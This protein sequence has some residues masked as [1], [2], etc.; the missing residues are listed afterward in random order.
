VSG[1]PDDLREKLTRLNE[2]SCEDMLEAAYLGGTMSD[3]PKEPTPIRL[4]NGFAC[5]ANGEKEPTYGEYFRRADYDALRTRLR[6]AMP[7]ETGPLKLDT[8][9]QV[10]FYEQ[11]HY[12]LS[13]FSAFSLEWEGYTFPTSEHAYQWEKFCGA[14]QALSVRRNIIRQS[15]SAHEAFKYAE[16]HAQFKRAN[17][18]SVKVEIMLNILRAKAE[19]HEYVRRK[20]LQTGDLELIENSWRDDFWGWGSNR[21]GQNMLGKLWMKVREELRIRDELKGE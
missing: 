2:F 14:G 5:N 9:T 15:R 21:D 18:D 19:Q 20:L 12:Y 16:T 8:D 3:L 17:W 6:K 1:C 7:S 13:N 4:R 10:F 11:E